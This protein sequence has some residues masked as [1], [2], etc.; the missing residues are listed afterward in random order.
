MSSPHLALYYFETC[1]FCIMVMRVIDDLNLKV[2][3]RDIYSDP[4][5]LQKLEGDT[6]KRTV[7]CL[8]IDG[9]PMF[10]SSDIMAWLKEHS[11][12]LEKKN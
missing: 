2:E 10:E 7:P 3:F 6:G 12:N 5:N 9:N 8:Y 1:P 11:P 4:A